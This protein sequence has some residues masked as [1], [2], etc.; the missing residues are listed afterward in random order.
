MKRSGGVAPAVAKPR[1]LYDCSDS[2]GITETNRRQDTSSGW[3]F[4]TRTC[5]GKRRSY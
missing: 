3:M 1:V 5:A 2:I 4:R